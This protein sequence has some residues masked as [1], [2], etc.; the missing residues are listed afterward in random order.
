MKKIVIVPKWLE[1]SLI[2]NGHSLKDAI[3]PDVISTTIS[4]DDIGFYIFINNNLQLFQE[5]SF[6]DFL[7]GTSAIN[8]TP[9]T[10][11]KYSDYILK[12]NALRG[13]G[14]LSMGEVLF[15]PL[16]EKDNPAKVFFKVTE[17]NEDTI[18]VIPEYGEVDN[19]MIET[20]KSL[21]TIMSKY[22]AFHELAKTSLFREYVNS[23]Y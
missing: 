1:A 13:S 10:A 14:L 7:T 19:A 4:N 21:L 5:K 23:A 16:S 20:V 8:F 3:S 15:G 18:A 9:E 22:L 17:L 2:A 11:E 12:Y 6:S